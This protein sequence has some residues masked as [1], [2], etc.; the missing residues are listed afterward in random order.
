MVSLYIDK[1]DPDA[2]NAFV[3]TLKAKVRDEY[4]AFTG[5]KELS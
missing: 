3:D 4:G 5:G 1:P 2:F